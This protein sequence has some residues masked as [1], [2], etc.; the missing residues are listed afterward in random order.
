M[1]KR[2]YVEKNSSC[3]C[4][5][6]INTANKDRNIFR[7]IYI[8]SDKS[9]EECRKC[10]L[11]LRKYY[12]YHE[13]IEMTNVKGLDNGIVEVVKAGDFEE[14]KKAL[15]TSINEIDK[16]LTY[17]WEVVKNESKNRN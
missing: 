17:L 14:L 11:K 1:W 8:P 15:L 13:D 5:I 9:K 6:Y 12:T 7:K 10:G 3:T 2:L 16:E 4:E